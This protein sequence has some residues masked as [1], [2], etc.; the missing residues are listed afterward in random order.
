MPGREHTVVVAGEAD[1]LLHLG[2]QHGGRL[3]DEHVLARLEREARQF[4]V[5][6]GV[7]TTTASTESSASTSAKLAVIRAAG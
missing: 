5:G 3:L 2:G 6:T 7:A 1:E 4:I